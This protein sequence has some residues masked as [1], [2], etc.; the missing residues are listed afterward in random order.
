[1]T[2]RK[3]WL[4]RG[5]SAKP[6]SSN[7]N[8]PSSNNAAP[9]TPQALPIT[10]QAN[11]HPDQD[12]ISEI[13]SSLTSDSPSL[14]HAGRDKFAEIGSASTPSAPSARKRRAH[15]KRLRATAEQHNKLIRDATEGLE[16]SDVA[17]LYAVF[18]LI[19][20]LSDF[21]KLKVVSRYMDDP[22]VS[23]LRAEE[24]IL[25]HIK[26]TLM[27]DSEKLFESGNEDSTSYIRNTEIWP[28]VYLE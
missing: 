26:G 19:S 10:P 28:V 7:I 11:A 2:G 14:A 15:A 24:R 25:C 6:D 13:G 4:F 27:P 9:I 3:G 17:E 20:Q 22:E 5:K 16:E 8:P 18:D 12:E 1:M 23:H 21:I